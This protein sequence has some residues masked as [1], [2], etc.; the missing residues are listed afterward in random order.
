MA[1]L[2][3]TADSTSL[4]GAA[5]RYPWAGEDEGEGDGDGDGEGDGDLDG[6]LDGDDGLAVEGMGVPGVVPWLVVG[7]SAI[8]DGVGVPL[9][10]AVR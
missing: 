5:T 10:A 6:D 3:L 7:V 2:P 4:V 1:A 8:T 9:A